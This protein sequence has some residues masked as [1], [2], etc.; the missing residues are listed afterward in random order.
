MHFIDNTHLNNFN[1]AGQQ[2]SVWQVRWR[3]YKKKQN[4]TE[5]AQ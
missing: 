5:T 2:L 1:W 3:K 4:Q